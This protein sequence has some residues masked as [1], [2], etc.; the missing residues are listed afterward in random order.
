MRNNTTLI[1]APIMGESIDKMKIDIDK[2]K[3]SGV[4]L[5]ELRVDYLRNFNPSEDL[6]IL[7]KGSPLPTLITYRFL[8][9]IL[10]LPCICSM[11]S[12]NLY[13]LYVESEFVGQYEH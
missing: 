7:I 1:C 10:F 4:D 8:D 9:A 3:A 13:L 12:L 5:V 11:L 2:A 6:S